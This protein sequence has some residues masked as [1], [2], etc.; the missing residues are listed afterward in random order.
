LCSSSSSSSIPNK[1]L[2]GCEHCCHHLVHTMNADSTPSG[3]QPPWATCPPEDYYH[4]HPLLQFII[5]TQPVGWC[6]FFHTMEDQSLSRPGWLATYPDGSAAHRWSPIPVLTSP[7]AECLCL[8][9]EICYRWAEAT[10][11][12]LITAK[13][14]IKCFNMCGLATFASFAWHLMNSAEIVIV[15]DL[16]CQAVSTDEGT[17]RGGEGISIRWEQCCSLWWSHF[18][19]IT[20]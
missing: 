3:C 15:S 6:T 18:S 4:L 14:D 20:E 1:Y 17:M 11:Q 10:P 2:Q 9:R 19:V 8:W 12:P 16:T 13:C 5:I 7:D